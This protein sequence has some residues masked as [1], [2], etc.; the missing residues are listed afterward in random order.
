MNGLFKQI[1]ASVSIP[2]FPTPRSV[3]HQNGISMHLNY[4]PSEKRIEFH[5]LFRTLPQ[6]MLLE[7]LQYLPATSLGIAMQASRDWY[8]LCR[9]KHLWKIQPLDQVSKM[10]QHVLNLINN[11]HVQCT[12]IISS[13]ASEDDKRMLLD[14]LNHPEKPQ[15]K[16]VHLTTSF[17]IFFEEECKLLSLEAESTD[18]SFIASHNYERMGKKTIVKVLI[19]KYTALLTL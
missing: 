2:L 11:S 15:S 14:M 3:L 17:E 13:T 4:R 16:T 6:E 10:T 19:Y 7:I 8:K 18:R 12:H 1:V 9:N 5:R